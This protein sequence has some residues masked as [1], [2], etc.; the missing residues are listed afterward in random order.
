M[1]VYINPI[2]IM[3]AVLL[4][5]FFKELKINDWLK[6]VVGFY[7]EE[8]LLFISYLISFIQKNI[9]LHQL[10]VFQRFFPPGSYCGFCRGMVFDSC[11][12]AKNK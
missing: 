11:G 6:K 8:C 1:E 4:F 12:M 10:S 5:L 2:V 3:Q 7:L 9:F